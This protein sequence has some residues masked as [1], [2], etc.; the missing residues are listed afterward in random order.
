MKQA[1]TDVKAGG[2]LGYPIAKASGMAYSVVAS[3]HLCCVS[4][5]CAQDTLQQRPRV[6]RNV[7]PESGCRCHSQEAK[8]C[9]ISK[10]ICD[11]RTARHQALP[12][13]PRRAA[14]QST[15]PLRLP[16]TPR[17]GRLGPGT[18]SGLFKQVSSLHSSD[19]RVSADL[20]H[21]SPLPEMN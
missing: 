11:S 9:H 18:P 19:H 12:L 15:A 3:S 8:L 7:S 6:E 14:H 1:G 2:C 16:P 5:N 20:S 17:K 10:N 21:C 13:S 4:I